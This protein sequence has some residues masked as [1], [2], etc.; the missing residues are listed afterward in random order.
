VLGPD[1]ARER[2]RWLVAVGLDD[3]VA[4]KIAENDTEPCTLALNVHGCVS[5]SAI[6]K[7]VVAE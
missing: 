3:L 6:K 2:W 7:R 5:L 1:S 4:S